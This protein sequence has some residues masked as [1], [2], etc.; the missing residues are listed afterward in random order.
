MRLTAPHTRCLSAN[1]HR[2][3]EDSE[4]YN[5]HH[6]SRGV[7]VRMP[8]RLP[9]VD[10]A[11]PKCLDQLLR[12]RSRQRRGSHLNWDL[13]I[14]RKARSVLPTTPSPSRSIRHPSTISRSSGVS[15]NE[16]A[17]RCWLS[18]RTTM[19]GSNRRGSQGRHRTREA[20]RPRPND[21]PLDCAEA[22]R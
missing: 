8:R 4:E 20:D 17:M 7:R 9:S 2:K 6:G 19:D 11:S 10:C 1:E 16:A 3:Q 5:R 13:H 18:A 15:E 21:V 14:R 22:Q 12:Q